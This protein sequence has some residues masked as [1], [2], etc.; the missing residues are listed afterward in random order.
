MRFS[1]VR[2]MEGIRTEHAAFDTE[3]DTW[4][5]D[6]GS[7]QVLGIGRYYREEQVLAL[8]NF[9]DRDATVWLRDEKPYTDLMEGSG[10]DAVSRTWL[11][12]K[13]APRWTAGT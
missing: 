7:D 4:L 9:G 8:F 12:L 1:A 5:L 10:A 3:A 2:R 13:N 11:W 6:T